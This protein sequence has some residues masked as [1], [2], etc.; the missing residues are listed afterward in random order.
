[1]SGPMSIF[2]RI[3]AA[4][5]DRSRASVQRALQDDASN[6]DYSNNQRSKEEIGAMNEPAATRRASAAIDATTRSDDGSDEDDSIAF[7]APN[8]DGEAS[9]SNVNIRTDVFFVPHQPPAND[10]QAAAPVTT[11]QPPSSAAVFAAAVA[12]DRSERGGGDDASSKSERKR[13]RP[14]AAPP[15]AKNQRDD[16]DDLF[17]E[18]DDE[19]RH[20]RHNNATID[21]GDDDD[22]KEK[23]P[24]NGKRAKAA[25]VPTSSSPP[26]K[27]IGG[28][29]DVL[30]QGG[31]HSIV[32][33]PYPIETAPDPFGR[34]DPA[35]GHLL[36][37]EDEPNAPYGP[38][39]TREKMARFVKVLADPI[40]RFTSRTAGMCN[41]KV[42]AFW[43]GPIDHGGNNIG[44]APPPFSNTGNGGRGRGKSGKKSSSGNDDDDEDD[45]AIVGDY[46]PLKYSSQIQA[47]RSALKALESQKRV[48]SD[49]YNDTRRT[50]AVTLKET[51]VGATK[52]SELRQ[53]MRVILGADEY[54]KLSD[55]W[56]A[57]LDASRKKVTDD[58]TALLKRINVDI[59]TKER[60][61]RNL[62]DRAEAATRRQT[63]ARG[64]LRS[65]APRPR[66]YQAYLNLIDSLRTDRSPESQR[67]INALERAA[68]ETS[69]TSAAT[70]TQ[71]SGNA[72]VADEGVEQRNYRRLYGQLPENFGVFFMS[73]VFEGALKL[74]YDAVLYVAKRKLFLYDLM[75]QESVNGRFALLV[76]KYIVEA[77]TSA[78]GGRF[79]TETARQSNT[80]TIRHLL[81]WFRNVSYDN[82]EEWNL[83]YM[84]QNP[85][86]SHEIQARRAS[87]ESF[88]GFSSSSAN[89][90]RN[91]V[92]ARSQAVR[93]S[94]GMPTVQRF[95]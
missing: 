28:P 68:A 67:F 47:L 55:N 32:N 10:D 11:S 37:L 83:L 91:E 59:T 49:R 30:E 14:V 94:M 7:R 26:E 25:P 33:W 46:D 2:Q 44:N 9:V 74:A 38:E 51:D 90:I 21:V 41:S 52:V 43:T 69:E 45:A 57:L 77:R 95:F 62:I 80:R 18:P 54:G 88:G 23:N 79:T 56:Q 48:E 89:D 92:R 29:F 63:V 34:V 40:Y 8:D 31:A 24:A 58:Q 27:K 82:T 86:Q 4:P 42:D 15:T 71:S 50:L 70:T 16:Y 73:S 84:G 6:D 13:D 1:M 20:H 87:L 61:L 93:A 12:A 17:F 60:E 64:F 19:R 5:S 72:L 3:F 22:E 81:D 76:A 65:A 53:M 85:Y 39:W 36:R 66:A 75:T 78:G 35:T